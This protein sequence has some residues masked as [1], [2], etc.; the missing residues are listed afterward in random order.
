[1][2]VKGILFS[3]ALCAAILMP[4]GSLHAQPAQQ[5]SQ[6][7]NL[8]AGE[9]K[10]QLTKDCTGCHQMGVITAEHK[11]ESQWTDTVIE[12]RGRGA[13][14][15]DDDMEKI[16]HY[17]AA[18]FGPQSSSAGA[19]TASSSAPVALPPKKPLPTP[20]AV[21]KEHFAALNACDWNRMMAQYDDKIAFL[22]KDGA[23]V[24]GRQAIGQMFKNALQPPPIGQCGMTLTPDRTIVVGDTV[25]VIWTATAPFFAEPYHGSEAFET[26]NG[27]LELQVTTWDPSAIKMKP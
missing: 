25:N 9:G 1:M 23:I 10:D 22:S 20:E 24:E 2:K 6:A 12:M 11:N 3:S 14:G 5:A 4:A 26:K 17:L 7:Q 27:L 19:S 21:V 8:P 18:N 15:S 13:T 16:V